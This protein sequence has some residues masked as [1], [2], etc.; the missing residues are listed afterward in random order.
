MRFRS[1]ITY[2]LLAT[3]LIA[4]SVY[5]DSLLPDED[6]RFV[7][8][9]SGN[10]SNSTS[11]SGS[12]PTSST[13]TSVQ[14]ANSS[15]STTGSDSGGSG[16]GGGD[17]GTGGSDS[18]TTDGGGNGGSGNASQAATTTGGGSGAAPTTTGGTGGTGGTVDPGDPALIDDMEDRNNQ[19]SRPY[20]GYWYTAVD[21]TGDGAVTPEAGDRVDA[22]ELMPVRDDSEYGMHV[23]GQ[24]SGGDNWAAAL[25][26][27]FYNDEDAIGSNDFTGITFY[28]RSDAP[29]TTAVAVE[30]MLTTV[31]DDGHFSFDLGAVL[32]DEWQEITILFSDAAD[33]LVQPTWAEEVTFN[34]TTLYKIQFKFG[35]DPFDLWVDDI[36]FLE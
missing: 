3:G 7:V 31:E 23:S 4:C 35:E 27:A 22:S 32:T 21:T 1:P 18:T 16:G 14:S 26:F 25:G 5:D 19:L 34:A 12:N 20:N 29:T 33:T 28:A 6:D 13:G 30:L 17:G 36:R 10:S 9:A 11:S 15:T 24:W 8:N 2:F